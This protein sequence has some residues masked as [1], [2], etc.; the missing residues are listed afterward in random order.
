MTSRKLT[1]CSVRS[2]PPLRFRDIGKPIDALAI[3][4][5]E[6]LIGQWATILKRERQRLSSGAT[7][8]LPAPLGERRPTASIAGR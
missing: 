7:V 4:D 8:P 3:H 1:A 2:Q 6:K 5:E